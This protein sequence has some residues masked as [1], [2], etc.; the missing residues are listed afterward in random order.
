MKATML[1]E[2]IPMQ[3]ED[4][5]LMGLARL[6]TIA[7][8]GQDLRP[9]AARLIERATLDEE[10]AN[11]LMDLSTVLML[12]GAR[13]L[14]LATQSQALQTQR[15]Y[16]LP[17][18]PGAVIRLLAVM[19]PG[20]LM[21][22]TPLPFL[23]EATG[24]A[25]SMLYVLPD[26]PLPEKL[27]E[28]D[29]LFVA[30]SESDRTR[31]LLRRL[32]KE[33]ADWPVPVCNHCD[34]ITRTSRAQAYALLEGAQGIQMPPSVRASRGR[35]RALGRTEL[36]LDVVLPGSSF[37]LI[38]RPVDSHAGH[39]LA[40]I[41]GPEGIEP[42]LAQTA[43]DNFFVSRF[44]DYSSADGLFRKYRV[45]LIEGVPYAAHM[46]ISSYWMIHYLNAGMT[47]SPAKRAEEEDFMVTFDL[48]GGFGRRHGVALAAVADRFGLD[49]LVMDCAE[50]PSGEL[51]VFE[52]DPGAVVHSMD[53]V[54]LFPYKRTHMEK[55]YNAFHAMLARAMAVRG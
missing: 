19:A 31:A 7:F 25:L 49:Y 45:V 30:V 26:E 17:A 42:Y 52:V 8:Q 9:L 4:T 43:G 51:L 18:P 55:I 22:N 6:M 48:E 23:A 47:D 24:I 38:M 20:D 5:S 21:T 10:D 33:L 36:A 40:R 41:D 16:S 29:V 27:P 13:E 44:V 32:G 28:H 46:G 11:A 14:G 39:G 37:P 15:V 12:Q 50:T 3:A 53:P 2:R 1:E 34:R 54:D 35:L